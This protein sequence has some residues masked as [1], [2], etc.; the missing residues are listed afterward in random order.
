MEPSVD[1]IFV[2]DLLNWDLIGHWDLGF[3]ILICYLRISFHRKIIVLRF[4]YIIP[5][6][7]SLR[8]IVH[9]NA[10]VININISV[11]VYINALV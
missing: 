6:F 3:G 10:E 4:N 5:H 8:P 9:H 2:W 1:H 11:L 7:P